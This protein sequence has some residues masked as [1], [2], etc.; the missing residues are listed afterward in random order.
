MVLGC[1]LSAYK[2]IVSIVHC[3]GADRIQFLELDLG[4]PPPEMH[5]GAAPNCNGLF[6]MPGSSSGILDE[7]NCLSLL[8]ELVQLGTHVT[9]ARVSVGG[10][11]SLA[12]S[13]ISSSSPFSTA[14]VL[15]RALRTKG[16]VVSLA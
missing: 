14:G 3:R 1:R 10:L 13:G 15:F 16:F 5:V 7:G 9:M 6:V 4:L 12:S 2:D 8:L 11:R